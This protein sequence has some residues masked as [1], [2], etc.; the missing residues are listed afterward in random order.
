MYAIVFDSSALG[1][2]G[3][4]VAGS[5]GSIFSSFANGISTVIEGIVHAIVNAITG[6][7]SS[8]GSYLYK[9]T[10]GAL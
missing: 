4:G 6:A 2:I 9:H 8:T 3:M 5:F 7:L 10:I 1:P